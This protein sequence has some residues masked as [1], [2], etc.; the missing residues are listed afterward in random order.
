M[1][2]VN[3]IVIWLLLLLSGCGGKPAAKEGAPS[4]ATDTDRQIIDALYL[5]NGLD[6]AGRR[7]C[8]EFIM[9]LDPDDQPNRTAT[10]YLRDSSSPLYNPALLDEYLLYLM[11]ALPDG[12][13]R[14]ERVG[15][16]L[17]CI[18]KNRSG[19][20]IADLDLLTADG[21][22]TSL[23][24]EIN[25]DACV[26]FYDPDCADCSALIEELGATD[27]AVI[28]ISIT[29]SIKPLPTR[30]LSARAIDADQLD[31]RFYLP[32]LPALYPVNSS[33]IIRQDI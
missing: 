4:V 24:C 32:A 22:R 14:R 1:W 8:W 23:H 17:D 33:A 6:S 2:R 25:T 11:A 18:R 29:D 9:E 7:D 5:A 31:D 28:A 15:Y 16:L 20:T 12:D 19:Q 10:E 21:R 27:V 26:L 3:L 13:L 30:W